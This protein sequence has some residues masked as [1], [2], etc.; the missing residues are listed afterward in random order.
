[1][2]I[3]RLPNPFLSPHEAASS[4][5][6]A[7]TAT[8]TTTTLTSQT[9]TATTAT[10]TVQLS[11][12][13]PQPSPIPR[14]AAWAEQSTTTAEVKHDSL[15]DP[16]T[17]SHRS[18]PDKSPSSRLVEIAKELVSDSSSSSSLSDSIGSMD[19]LVALHTAQS[20]FQRHKPQIQNTNQQQQQQQ[21][22]H[23]QQYQQQQ[24]QQ[25]HQQQ[26]QQHQQQQHKYQQYQQQHQPRDSHGQENQATFQL[27]PQSS[28]V[29]SVDQLYKRYDALHKHIMDLDQHAIV[30]QNHAASTDGRIVYKEDAHRQDDDGDEDGDDGE[31]KRLYDAYLK[32]RGLSVTDPLVLPRTSMQNPPA[33]HLDVPR[34][35][36]NQKEQ[37]VNK[38]RETLLDR[39]RKSRASANDSH[40]M[41]SFTKFVQGLPPQHS[42]VPHLPASSKAAP[43]TLKIQNEKRPMSVGATES[44]QILS[45][46]TAH[47]NLKRSDSA[48]FH[49][50]STV[51][52][53][54]K[55]E[56]ANDSREASQET[57]DIDS[58]SPYALLAVERMEST[59]NQPKLWSDKDL[60]YH[61]KPQSSY[62]PYASQTDMNAQ[63]SSLVVECGKSPFRDS[64]HSYIYDPLGEDETVPRKDEVAFTQQQPSEPKDVYHFKGD[65]RDPYMPAQT[66][67]PPQ[68]PP[69]T[70][71]QPQPQAIIDLQDENTRLKRQLED[72]EATL[73][74][75]N[76][77]IE[78][79]RDAIKNL[80]SSVEHSRP[81]GYSPRTH[82]AQ[83]RQWANSIIDTDS[84]DH[85]LAVKGTSL[86]SLPSPARHALS[87]GSGSG[88]GSGAGSRSGDP[89]SSSTRAVRLSDQGLDLPQRSSRSQ[90]TPKS[91]N[92]FDQ[93]D[94]HQDGSVQERQSTKSLVF[95][96]EPVIK[97]R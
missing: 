44:I 7:T 67:K 6:P 81:D 55:S 27:G 78:C 87:S 75:Q 82:I 39:L 80:W 2:S 79:L 31:E 12:P 54:Y 33:K 1:M 21:H 92:L 34:T 43:V 13:Q 91:A 83:W 35:E 37:A 64:L 84:P 36:R 29:A 56:P 5:I 89:V 38:P 19:S 93:Q 60:F 25:Q 22:H 74:L 76:Q 68:K 62:Q 63:D 66:H 61:S 65:D 50:A 49:H 85:K 73:R 26:Q 16:R 32:S 40:T 58:Q 41:E 45:P 88:A 71:P 77:K 51:F 4:T 10:A 70:Q 69:Q 9:K 3:R 28:H 46:A 96:H 72:T 94:Q 24:Q 86:P 42:P 23:Q 95:E 57:H 17:Q 47:Q 97:Y 18:T 53:D 8:A 11:Q 30:V 90:M 52:Q 59:Q 14:N 48:E 15:R 20:S